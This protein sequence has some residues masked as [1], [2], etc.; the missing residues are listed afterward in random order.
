[1][2]RT[3]HRKYSRLHDAIISSYEV[4]DDG[5]TMSPMEAREASRLSRWYNRLLLQSMKVAGNQ[6]DNMT[7]KVVSTVNGVSQLSLTHFLTPDHA[8]ILLM[9]AC[10]GQT[11]T[12]DN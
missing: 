10:G 6:V 11:C 5:P 4:T 12:P 1:M 9:G 8:L 3:L 7:F 2:P